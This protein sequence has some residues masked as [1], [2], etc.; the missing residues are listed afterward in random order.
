M[1]KILITAGGT[2]SAYF[3]CKELRRCMGNSVEIYIVDINE[4][5]LIP[6][7]LLADRF[8]QVPPVKHSDYKHTL[9]TLIE[10]NGIDLI[11]PLIDLDLMQFPADDTALAAISSQSTAPLL[12]VSQLLSDKARLS[13]ALPKV[14]IPVPDIFELSSVDSGGDYFVKPKIGFGSRGASMM[15][16]EAILRTGLGPEMLIQEICEGPEVTVE[17]FAHDGRLETICRERIEVK[18]GVCTKARVF[19]DDTLHGHIQSIFDAFELPV[20]SCFQFMKNQSGVWCLTDANLRIG[21]GSALCAAI[22]WNLPLASMLVWLGRGDEASSL[23]Q[24][25]GNERHVVRVFE[26]IVTV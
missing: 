6:S 1:K 13:I 4:E 7:A 18:A 23:L 22:G 16:G 3:F 2:A 10:E 24:F 19:R 14:G 21:A 25:D 17:V 8:F 15:S 20:A 9:L 11:V 26:E 12:S 5:K